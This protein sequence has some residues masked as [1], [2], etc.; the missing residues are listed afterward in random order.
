MGCDTHV[1]QELAAPEA[2]NFPWQGFLES[3][4]PLQSSREYGVLRTPSQ[5]ISHPQV[6]DLLRQYLAAH[7]TVVGDV[8]TLTVCRLYILHG[9]IQG[10]GHFH[11]IPACHEAANLSGPF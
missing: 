4:A 10:A 5:P 6:P 7:A 2:R 3:Q 9:V 8:S 1:L 11:R